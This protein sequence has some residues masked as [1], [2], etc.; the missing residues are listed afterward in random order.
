MRTDADFVYR[1][2]GRSA[3][4]RPGAHRSRAQ[5]PG[6]SF[7]HY[8]PLL[9][10][11][12]PRRLDLRASIRNVHGGWLVRASRQRASTCVTVL[13]DVSSSMHF[14]HPTRKLETAARFLDSLGRSA[15]GYGDALALQAFDHAPRPDLEFAARTG[16]GAGAALASVIRQLPTPG[17][18]QA[19][20]PHTLSGLCAGLQQNVSLLFLVSDFHWP[21]TYLDAAFKRLSHQCVVPIVLWSHNETRPPPAGRWV[22]MQDLETGRSRSMISR[23]STL[24]RWQAN[25]EHRRQLIDETL[26]ANGAQPF[27][28]DRGFDARALSRHF[29]E[30][31]S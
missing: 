9:D 8:L 11:P 7:S 15:F 30:S 1:I 19:L 22:R 24:A 25:I 29:M 26:R 27:F 16:R 3:S 2:P 23:R 13:M 21:L 10:Q 4:Y 31:L 5:G 20:Q 28:M 6:L 18:H 14:G 17:R 12:D